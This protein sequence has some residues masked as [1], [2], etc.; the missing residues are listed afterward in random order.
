MKISICTTEPQSNRHLEFFLVQSR[1]SFST[2]RCLTN[3][4]HSAKRKKKKKA[5]SDRLSYNVVR[6]TKGSVDGEQKR[7]SEFP[8]DDVAESSHEGGRGMRP[9]AF[10]PYTVTFST[11]TDA[12][13]IFAR[14]AASRKWMARRIKQILENFLANNQSPAERYIYSNCLRIPNSNLYTDVFF[15]Q[16]EN[17]SS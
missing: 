10:G 11:R 2:L 13:Y 5:N 14:P 16:L 9:N 4:R 17:N 7:V 15:L 12:K 1:C 8:R 6:G 3:V